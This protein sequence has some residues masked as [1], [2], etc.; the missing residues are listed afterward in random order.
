MEMENS[1]EVY[2]KESDE[3][4][5]SPALKGETADQKYIRQNQTKAGT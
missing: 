3:G 4:R 5:K 1:Y 2:T